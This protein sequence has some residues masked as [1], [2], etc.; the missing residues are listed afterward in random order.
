MLLVLGAVESSMRGS[1]PQLE[2]CR[3]PT[4]F[5]GSVENAEIPVEL[6]SL[7]AFALPVEVENAQLEVSEFLSLSSPFICPLIVKMH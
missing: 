5:E 6:L 2:R 7:S 3:S 1:S 4:F